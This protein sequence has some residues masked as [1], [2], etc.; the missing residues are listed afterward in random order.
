MTPA[1]TSEPAAVEPAQLALMDG[2]TLRSGGAVQRL[3][4]SAQRLVALVALRGGAISRQRA[5]FTLWPD[6]S[7]AHAYGSLRTALFRLRAVCP[8]GSV[9]ECRSEFELSATVGVDVP[10]GVR[11]GNPPGGRRHPER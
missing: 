3:S 6:A 7:E 1:S 11:A 10:E 8:G 4:A 9:L 2:F 5:A